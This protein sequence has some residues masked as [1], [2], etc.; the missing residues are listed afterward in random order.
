[1]KVMISTLAVALALASGCAH[2][3]AYTYLPTG[4]ATAGGPAARYLVP[5]AAPQG[6]L[7]V[8]SFGFTDFDVGGGQ[9]ARMVHARLAVSNGGPSPLTV[10]GRAQAL[11]APGVPREAA[12]FLNTD[13]GTGPVYVV[14][15]GR[16]NVFDLYFAVPPPLADPR[17]LGA[18]ALDWRVD[19]AGVAVAERTDFQ[20]FGDVAPS[21]AAYPPYV[22]V[23]LGFGVGWWYGPHWGYRR[24]YPPMI[25]GYYDPPRH[26]Y[27]RAWRGSPPG[28]WRGS[29]SG[30]WRGAP[31]RAAPPSGAWRG[32]PGPGRH[33]GGGA[34]RRR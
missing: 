31:P 5:P 1:M 19:V 9:S 30:A 26:A 14:E 4:P 13:A 21:Y 16:T 17:A 2:E 22:T 10:D 6:E 18:F 24:A 33:S 7:Y 15:A 3:A 34:W 11:E 8:T 20:R 27:G 29:P 12:S 28:A 25:H 32:S 23:G